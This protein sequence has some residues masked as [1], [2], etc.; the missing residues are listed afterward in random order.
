MLPTKRGAWPFGFQQGLAQPLPPYE[1]D[2]MMY[3]GSGPTVMYP[4]SVPTIPGLPYPRLGWPTFTWPNAPM[5]GRPRAYPPASESRVVNRLIAFL[6]GGGEDHDSPETIPN[7]RHDS[8]KCQCSK[9][10]DR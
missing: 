5:S 7:S 3:P 10:R 6:N 2:P 4:G 1:P 9:C 8:R